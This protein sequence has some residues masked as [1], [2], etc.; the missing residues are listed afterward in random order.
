[1]LPYILHICIQKEYILL[2]IAYVHSRF[3]MYTSLDTPYHSH[4]IPFGGRNPICPQVRM[5]NMRLPK[6]LAKTKQIA[7]V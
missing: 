1:M 2:Y 6:E 5:S 7:R 3:N 4:K